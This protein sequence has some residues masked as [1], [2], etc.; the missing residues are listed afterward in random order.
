MT[1]IG[2]VLGDFRQLPRLVSPERMVSAVHDALREAHILVSRSGRRGNVAHRST[3]LD[4]RSGIRHA[5]LQ[6]CEISGGDV[7]KRQAQ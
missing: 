3:D 5:Q 6:A 1:G 2:E 7:Y 4:Q